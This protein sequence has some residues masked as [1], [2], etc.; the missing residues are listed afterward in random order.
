MRKKHIKVCSFLNNIELILIW[1]SAITG[2]ISISTCTFLLGI[3]IR[4]RFSAIGL[5]FCAIAAGVKNYTSI[6]KKKEPWSISTVRKTKLVSIEVLIAK[7]L[8]ES[9]ISQDEFVLENNVLK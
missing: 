4:I 3:P 8:T 1:A 5:K 7:A 6:I 2:C 9:N